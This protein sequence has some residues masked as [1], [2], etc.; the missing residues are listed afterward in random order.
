MATLFTK[1]Y[2]SWQSPASLTDASSRVENMLTPVLAAHFPAPTLVV[3][4]PTCIA[5]ASAPQLVTSVG[6]VQVYSVPATLTL[7][8][9]DGRQFGDPV[10]EK[11]HLGLTKVAGK[12]LVDSFSAAPTSA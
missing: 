11:V 7:Y 6:A 2:L 3:E 9:Q 1:T 10:T 5:S 8:A 4:A 12:W